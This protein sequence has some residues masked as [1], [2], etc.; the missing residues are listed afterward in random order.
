MGRF[1]HHFGQHNILGLLG[2]QE[3]IGK[4]GW[5]WLTNE[6]TPCMDN[7]PRKIG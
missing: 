6:S 7:K 5:E 1:I 3:F 4:K 2:D